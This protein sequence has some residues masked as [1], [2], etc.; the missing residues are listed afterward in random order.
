MAL[1]RC[2]QH[3]PRRTNQYVTF[4][5]PIGYPLTSSVCGRT[6]CNEPGLVFLNKSEELEYLNHNQRIFS[7]ASNVTK[8]KVK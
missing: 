1:C 6:N 4:V 5:E 3:T 7:F 8:V 2:K